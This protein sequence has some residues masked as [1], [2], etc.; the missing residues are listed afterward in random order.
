MPSLAAP[1]SPVPLAALLWAGMWAG[2]PRVASKDWEA[3]ECLAE[4]MNIH[5]LEAWV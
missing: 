1:S 4:E 5:Q 3:L 2:L